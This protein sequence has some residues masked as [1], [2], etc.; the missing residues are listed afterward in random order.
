V[1]VG[2]DFVIE[3]LAGLWV[4][5][6]GYRVNCGFVGA[7]KGWIWRLAGFRGEKNTGVSWVVTDS[8]LTGPVS[9]SAG[10]L[11]CRGAPG[12]ILRACCIRSVRCTC[13]AVVCCAATCC[14]VVCCLHGA[15]QV[16]LSHSDVFGMTTLS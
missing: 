3:G 7:G 8:V 15:V 4:F 11:S 12:P 14:V 10:V 2:Y 5:L 9:S 1:P 13:C 16:V 6:V